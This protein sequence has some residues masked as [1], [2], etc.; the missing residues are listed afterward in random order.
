MCIY[1]YIIFHILYI[2]YICM[3]DY[4]DLLDYTP[5]VERLQRFITAKRG[6]IAL[7]AMGPLKPDLNSKHPGLGFRDY[8]A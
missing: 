1:C 6:D 4:P 7:G 8:R 3:D 2:I 5:Q